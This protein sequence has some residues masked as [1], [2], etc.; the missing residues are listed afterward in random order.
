ML[1]LVRDLRRKSGS[2]ELP[3]EKLPMIVRLQKIDAP[4]SMEELNPCDFEAA[5][6][7]GVHLAYASFEITNDPV[8]PMP[9]NCAKWLSQERNPRGNSSSY[10]TPTTSRRIPLTKCERRHS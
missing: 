4:A 6:G 3:V 8:T 7:R 9:P 1:G 2:I 10:C 5:Y